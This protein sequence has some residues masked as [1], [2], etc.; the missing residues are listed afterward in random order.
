MHIDLA[1]VFKIYDRILEKQAFIGG[2]IFTLGDLFHLPFLT[3]LKNM[4]EDKLWKDLPNVARW[5]KDIME[6][7][8]WV[9]VSSMVK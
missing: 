1:N 9:K 7:P 2:E 5:A 4:G 6:R 8:V 3:L